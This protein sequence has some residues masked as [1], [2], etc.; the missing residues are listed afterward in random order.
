MAQRR[1]E[2]EEHWGHISGVYANVVWEVGSGHGH[3]LAAYAQ[4]HSDK[5]CLGI[6]IASDRISRALR[7][8]DR[9]RLKNLHFI[10]AEARFF[11]DALPGG[12]K[13]SEIFILFP[14]PWPKLRH[15][16]HRILQPDFLRAAAAR[17]GDDC[18]LYFRTDYRPYF[19]DAQQ[20]IQKHADWKLV[21]EP[22]P[23]EFASVFQTRA[24]EYQS[25]IA[26]RT[27]QLTSSISTQSGKT[28]RG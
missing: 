3:F 26:Q 23:F 11:L 20:V 24:S 10:R 25:L 15:R 5:L 19:E 12:I 17:A 16:K 8:R 4:A 27:P 21:D 18:R 2:L 13:L 22:W 14:D 9:A 7:K 6:D 28:N 1:T